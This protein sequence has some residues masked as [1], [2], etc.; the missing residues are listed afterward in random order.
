MSFKFLTLALCTTALVVGNASYNLAYA[1]FSQPAAPVAAPKAAETSASQ[2]SLQAA[3]QLLPQRRFTEAVAALRPMVNSTNPA[4]RA[5]SRYLLAYA[6]DGLG[7]P[8]QALQV[9]EGTL[10]DD[11]PLGRA[12]GQ[13]RG[14]LLLQAAERALMSGATDRAATFLSDYER[15]SVQPDKTRYNRLRDALNPP[16]ERTSLPPLRVGVILPQTGP[17]AAPGTDLLRAL[18]L[19]LPEFTAGNRRV[20]LVVQNATTPAEAAS[21]A[22]FLKA[23]NVAVVLGPLLANQVA[24]VREKLGSTPL[25]TFSSDA[26]VLGPQTHTLNFLPAQQASAV[27]VAAMASGNTAKIGALVPQGAYGE[28]TLAGLKTALQARGAEPVVISFYNPAETDIGS[29]IRNLGKGFNALLLPAQARNLPLIA[30]QLAYYDLDRGVQLLGT[31]LWQDDA[32]GAAGSS[33]LLAPSASAL[34]GSLFAAPAR[35]PAFVASFTQAFGAAP[36]PLAALGY[37]TA[38][39]LAQLAAENSRSGN[40]ISQI[41]LRPEGFYAPGGFAKF[42]TNGQTVRSLAL[43][44]IGNGQFTE[45]QPA[46]ALAPLPLPN[47]LIPEAGARSWW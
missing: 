16:A 24:G 23:Q 44:E 10:T 1:Q 19:G 3:A 21:A 11:T 47:P 25:L 36:H 30:A 39:I 42:T 28:A 35:N 41:L 27:A 38:A 43:T 29:S 18:Q 40:A 17:L 26:E 33:A 6:L 8:T 4:T 14:Q 12:I 31:A 7:D 5:Q 45:R 22:T 20:E 46:L 9:L 34:R 13:L 37:D 2:G 15:L 32:S